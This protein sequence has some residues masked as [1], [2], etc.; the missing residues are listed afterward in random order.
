MLK[1]YSLRLDNLQPSQLQVIRG[2]VAY[3]V[4]H[5]A[6]VGTDEENNQLIWVVE[7]EVG[8]RIKTIMALNSDFYTLT[9]ED[10]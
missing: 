3:E 6:N 5:A 10:A 7:E 4:H 9:E 1:K 8:E 2:Y